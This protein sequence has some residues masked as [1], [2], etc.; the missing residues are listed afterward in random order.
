MFNS[1]D[2]VIFTR[3][4]GKNMLIT[5]KL[6]ASRRAIFLDR[7]IQTGKHWEKLGNFQTFKT[8]SHSQLFPKVPKRY[9][10]EPPCSILF[11]P[12]QV[13]RKSVRRTG[14][15]LVVLTVLTSSSSC[16]VHHD[17]NHLI[18]DLPQRDLY[19]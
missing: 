16:E 17:L 2:K 9:T 10:L 8:N 4:I 14:F 18:P 3:T 6:V 19:I 12:Q 1:F 7:K 11:S 13:L 15:Q 5:V